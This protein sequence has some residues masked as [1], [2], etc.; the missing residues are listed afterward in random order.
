MTGIAVPNGDTSRYWVIDPASQSA[1]QFFRGT[2][3]PTG[4]APVLLPAG[5]GL[6]GAAVV[7]DHRPGEVLCVDEIVANVYVCVDVATSGFVCSFTNCLAGGGG[8][9]FGNGLGDAQDTSICSG[10][11]L[12]V[13][14]GS[15]GAG[16]VTDVGQYDCNVADPACKN[17][18]PIAPFSTFINGIEETE[19]NG[20]PALAIADNVSATFLVIQE[21]FGAPDCRGRDANMDVLWVNGSQGGVHAFVDVRSSATLSVADQRPPTGDGRFVH[22]MYAG[23]PSAATRSTLFDLGVTCF[24]MLSGTAVVVENNAG[25]TNLVGASSYFGTAIPNPAKSPTFLAS[26]LQ[27]VIDSANMPAGSTW[28]HQAIHAN[29]ASSSKRGASLSNAIEVFMR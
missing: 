15:I 11:T 26:L 9:A 23:S 22:H 5:G 21:C 25:K 24:D 2:G 16:Q 20:F 6:Y 13:S 4:A 8:G 3:M 27:P 1:I 18:W 7:D 17:R 14:G 29:S 12:V 19:I 10:A 28:L